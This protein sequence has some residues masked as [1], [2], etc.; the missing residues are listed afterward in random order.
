MRYRFALVSLA[1]AGGSSCGSHPPRDL[2]V[3][4]YTPQG[5]IDKAG[6]VEIRFDK[7]AVGEDMVG[8]AAAPNAVT[9]SPAVPWR[10]FWQDRQTLVI[11]PTD[12]LAP[13]TRYEVALAGDLGKRTAAFSFDFV[14]RPL[15]IE[16]LSGTDAQALAPDG[17]LAIA[18]NQP[19]RAKDA[20]TH[21]RLAGSISPIAL[22]ADSDESATTIP[23]RPAAKLEAGK[24]YKLTCSELSGDGG[25]ATLAKAYELD[26]RARPLLA[27]EKLEPSGDDIPADEVKLSFHFT[28]PVALDAARKSITAHP[29]IKGIDEGALSGDGTEYTVTAD[30]ETETNYK[31]TIKGLEDVYG[32][33]L[34]KTETLAFHTGD[35]RPRLSLER[36]IF[37]LEASAKGYPVWSRNV[38]KFDVECAQIPKE[39]LVQALTTDMNYDPWGGNNDDQPID[40][41]KL[42]AKAKTVHEKAEK[43]NKWH[44]SELD[45]GATCGATPG[46]RGVYLAEMRSD[47]VTPDP[48]RGWL[49]PRRNRVLAN[50]TDMGVLIKTG[51]ASGLVWVTSLSS[52]LPVA[53]AKVTVF[54]P[55]GKQVWVDSTDADGIVKI[56]GSVLLKNQ[57]PL[58]DDAD[59]QYDWDYYRAQRLIATVEKDTDLAVVDGNW[60]NG[61]Q[62]WNFG[63][64][65]DR[66]GTAIRIRGFIQSDRGL[67]RPGESVHFKGIVREIAAGNPPRVPEKGKVAIEVAD[68]RG[69]TIHT[70]TS[71]LSDFGGFSFDMDLS[72]EAALGDYYVSAT[73]AGQV[74]REK[75]SVEEF[76]PATFEVKL[77]PRDKTPKPGA[78]LAFDL[79]AKY[80]FGSPAGDAK[81]EW[82]LRKRTHAV[83][84]PG[85]DDYTF[86]AD[87]NSWW[88][89]EPPQD[90]GEFIG[91]G[92]GTTNAQGH[93]AISTKD[94]ATKFDGPIDYIL[95]ASVTDSAD[96]TMGKSVVVT[97]HKTGFYLGMHANEFVQAV[98]MPFGVNLVAMK[99]DGTRTQ[100]KA[101]LTFTRSERSCMWD[102]IGARSYERCES[103]PKVMIERDVDIEAGGSHTERI[104]PT[105]PGEYIVKIESKDDAGNPVV[106]ASEIWVIGK[107]EAFWSGD[108]GARMTL[109]ASKASYEI[110]EKARLVAQANLVTP[111]ALVTIERDGIIDAK[112]VKMKSA[113]EGVELDIKDAWAPNVFAGVALVS[114]RHGDGDKNRP[115]FKMGMV[116]LEVSSKQKE[117]DVG[118]TLDTDKVRPGDKVTGRIKVTRGGQ[119]V[120]SE[121]S[122]SVADEGVLQLI[123]YQTPNPMKTF[124]AAYGL[125]VD[126]GTSWNRIARL[127]DPES[128]DP[129]EGGDRKSAGDGQR[130]RSKF[131][132]SAFWAPALVTDD[133]GEIPFAFTAP[134]NLT[135]FRL[136][137]VAADMS[138]QFGAGETRLTVNKPLMAAPTL[139][140]FLHSGDAAAV[141]IVIHNNTDKAGTAIVTAKANGAALD[142]TRQTIAVAAGGT[143]RVRFGAKAAENA[144]AMFDFT[145]AMN[146]TQDSVRVTIPIEKPRTIQTRTLGETTLPVNGGW[147]GTIGAGS[148]V[149]RKESTLVVTVDRS[150]VGELAPSLRALVEY[151]YGCLE[152]T[153]SKF[154]PLVAAKD[155]ATTLDDP[156][157]QGSKMNQYIK[158]GVAKVI[159]HQQGDGHFSLWPQSQTY[160]HLTAYAL[161]GL[162]VAQSAG[163]T[164]PND[165]FD[166]GVS[167]LSAW[168]NAPGNLK[169]NGDGATM[170]MAAYVMAL[171]GKAD[172]A[173]DARL[174]AIRDGLPVWGRAFLLRA[175][176][177]AK[178]DAAQ[179]TE[180]E[181]QITDGIK[182]KDGQALV[183]ETGSHS[184]WE[185]YMGSDVRATAMTLAALVEVDPQ[186]RLI[187][188]LAAGL[189]AERGH[190]GYWETTQENVWALVALAQYA[191]RSTGGASVA[192]VTVG[193][194]QVWKKK[195]VGSEIGVARIALADLPADDVAIVVDQGAH[196]TARVVEARVDAGAP[197]AHGFSVTRAYTDAKGHPLMT[198]K[199]GDLVTVKL[200]VHADAAHKWVALVDPL[201][202]GFE[203]VNP[204]LAAGQGDDPTAAT[205]STQ[206]H[207][208]WQE[209]TWDHQ[210]MRDDRVQWFADDMRAGDYQLTY[211]VRATTSGTFTALPATI[212]AMYEPDQH[213]RSDSSTV[214]IGK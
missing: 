168:A 24:H 171:R 134:D 91:D 39:K 28:T 144:A 10:G 69:Q 193:G 176:K 32:Q 136:M 180:L 102:Q 205:S 100:A 52:G 8:K 175:M 99:P 46:A 4:S 31:I 213:G 201:V 9:I 187:D 153:M 135:A 115:Q 186:S 34:A 123:A 197:E 155:L 86:S 116:K 75:F 200:E 167:A 64:P 208:W 13:S 128:G 76:K 35:A 22:V 110:G 70:T 63:L 14:H 83:R 82:S 48:D 133:K 138:D 192:T 77:E 165:V 6:P 45:L 130:V 160:P 50:V 27:V 56:P 101:H 198:V 146:G 159:R 184:D 190:G 154:V 30:L 12:K 36:G 61:I 21:C 195:V 137:A 81:V 41:K 152:Q 161:W 182:V 122:L 127:A 203:V 207:R 117:L 211:Q 104:Y 85:F 95:S 214:T 40:W 103:T 131:V 158:A 53:G 183:H 92:S 44:L 209:A 96:Q 20:S 118:I 1:L 37:A 89:W 60:A 25:N 78:R 72:S 111:T 29:R 80:L 143:A 88:W 164:V 73:V 66:G 105:D 181:K 151:P 163:V 26:V 142:G 124:Y 55:E 150:G 149:L 179:V 191:K 140:R 202:A 93:L 188:P 172:P 67:Y 177:L 23:L 126:A 170:A 194:K 87:P 196:V 157:L 212:E 84:F 109:I 19:V 5:A 59:A 121:V 47:E 113:S 204:K 94:P 189:K 139:P 97:A 129:D 3:M 174:Y 51:T 7:P 145:V 120:R 178:A 17:E 49:S 132:S 185:M 206:P 74:F 119:P 15:V 108:E 210:D 65:E 90:Y 114:G 71:K 107:G 58:G 125:G 33:K 173:L 106:A 162:S 141:G 79:D 98:G 42:K 2:K 54:T 148:D 57:K 169:P 43:K 156:S 68:S 11:E 38:G 166:R 16:G 199:A 112:V 18:F 62:I 147:S